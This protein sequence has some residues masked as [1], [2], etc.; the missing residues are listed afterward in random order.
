VNQLDLFSI[1]PAEP[2]A[3]QSQREERQLEERRRA[4]EGERTIGTAA[5][6]KN[7]CSRHRDAILA[8][9]REGSATNGDLE[10]VGGNRFGARIHEL[11][12]EGH[13]IEIVLRDKKSGLTLYRLKEGT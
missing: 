5:D 9:L 10:A 8:L 13:V 3:E 2:T 11:R 6:E 4:W 7:R 1:S 12:K